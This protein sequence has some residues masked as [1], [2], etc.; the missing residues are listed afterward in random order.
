M[1]KSGRDQIF[2]AFILFTGKSFDAIVKEVFFTTEDSMSLLIVL[3][4]LT[5]GLSFLCS[6]MEA[7]LLSTTPSYISS[8]E[9]KRPSAYKKMSALKSNVDRPLSAILMLNTIANTAGASCIGAQVQTV[10][11]NEYIAA[12]SAIMT[13]LILLCSEI[14]PK[15]IGA[16]YWQ[17]LTGFLC[18][19]LPIM[20]FVFK[21]FMKLFEL[22]TNFIKPKNQPKANI[23]E[24]IKSMTKMGY[25]EKFLDDD[26]FHVISNVLNLDE[27]KVKDLLTPRSVCA[28]VLADIPISEF[29]ETATE[30][31]FSRYPVMKNE[32]EEVFLGYVHKSDLI[33]KD[34]TQSIKALVR[35]ILEIASTAS[36]DYVFTEMLRTHN[37][38]GVVYDELGTWLGIITME[39]V[40]EAI[41]GKEIVDET[42]TVSDMQSYAKQLW[43]TKRAE[44]L[45]QFEKNKA[46][47]AEGS[48]TDN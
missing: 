45:K 8:L 20:L 36:A 25:T 46:I 32:D 13:V 26:E 5:V 39:D 34:P 41:L 11:G 44:T 21:P 12:A 1:T 43:S 37:H 29:I 27:I 30:Y 14:I 6:L 17:K 4:V 2:A 28:T 33:G 40:L 19:I 24:E 31:A 22:M 7:A 47:A 23:R 3:V 48:V 16:T 35:P 18:F 10:L 38:I 9:E 42:D 15:T